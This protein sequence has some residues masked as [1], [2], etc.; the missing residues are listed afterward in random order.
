MQ[1]IER[2]PPSASAA[3]TMTAT[4][5]EAKGKAAVEAKEAGEVEATMSDIDRVIS[6]VIKDVA[7]EEDMA[8]TPDEEREIDTGP[9]GKEDFDLR[10]L[11]GQELSKEEK[12]KLK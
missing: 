10:H 11:G 6:D 8:T 5:A 9:S 3:K 12:L 7:A 2:T 1:A 4:G